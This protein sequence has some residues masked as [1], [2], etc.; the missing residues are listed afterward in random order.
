[1]PR[2]L[3]LPPCPGRG[4]DVLLDLPARCPFPCLQVWNVQ[5]VSNKHVTLEPKKR[6]GLLPAAL[7]QEKIA[8]VGLAALPVSCPQG[9]RLWAASTDGRLLQ[10]RLTNGSLEKSVRIPG[11]RRALGLAAANGLIAC[12][13]SNGLFIFHAGTLDMAA[14]IKNLAGPEAGWPTALTFSV[15]GQVLTAAYSS[16][17]VAA[18]SLSD[19]SAPHQL[20]RRSFADV[21]GPKGGCARE[22]EQGTGEEARGAGAPTAGSMAP[23]AVLRASTAIPLFPRVMAALADR[24]NLEAQCLIQYESLE[25]Q[26]RT[27]QHGPLHPR[28]LRAAGLAEDP[29]EDPP[30]NTDAYAAAKPEAKPGLM[31]GSRNIS[32]PLLASGGAGAVGEGSGSRG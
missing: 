1:M 26:M 32:T 17:V 5:R 8:F 18:W 4:T 27:L 16:N 9:K 13:C 10:L 2:I 7:I 19:V 12:A 14:T 25:A 30:A 24:S 29:P 15:S 28:S 31:P 11:A 6:M 21:A 3:L 22:Q 23:S 20:F